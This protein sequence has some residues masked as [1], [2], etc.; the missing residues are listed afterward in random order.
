MVAGTRLFALVGASLTVYDC[1]L[2]SDA[3]V[4]L[5]QEQGCS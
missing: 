3:Q 5:I 4:F 1:R 2:R